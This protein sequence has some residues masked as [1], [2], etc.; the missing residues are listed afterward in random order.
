MELGH[1]MEGLYL[2]SKE[3]ENNVEKPVEEKEENYTN[4]QHDMTIDQISW[5]YL[6]YWNSIGVMVAG[7]E[8]G[9]E[10]RFL[11]TW[12]LLVQMGLDISPINFLCKIISCLLYILNSTS[13]IISGSNGVK[14][15]MLKLFPTD[16]ILKVQWVL[17]P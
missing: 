13:S 10:V 2:I 14:L 6:A 7:T 9:K 16:S 12:W 3:K 8:E 17:I 1:D 15:K 4:E 11:L 5:D